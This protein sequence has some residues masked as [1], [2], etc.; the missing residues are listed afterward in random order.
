MRVNELAR[1]PLLR[2]AT[3]KIDVDVEAEGAGILKRAVPDG[4]TLEP[5]SVL[6]WLLAD[7]EPAPAGAAPAVAS[8]ASVESDEVVVITS[9]QSNKS[10]MYPVV[11]S[12][13]D[14][15]LSPADG[16]VM[17]A[18][19]AV[20]DAVPAGEWLQV[21][22]FLSPMD[23]HVNRIPVSG[24]VTVSAAISRWWRMSLLRW[25]RW[26]PERR[27][28]RSAFSSRARLCRACSIGPD[29]CCRP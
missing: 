1:L 16:R 5:G 7:G 3:D 2:L 6:G 26:R 13:A 23:V 17:I 14:L 28:S 8:P 9:P 18:G 29:A 25:P 12:V 21:S 4:A 11:Y 24:R 27:A 22:I 20:P 19:A 15:V 10:R